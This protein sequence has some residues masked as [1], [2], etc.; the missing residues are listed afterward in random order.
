MNEIEMET[1]ERRGAPDWL[2]LSTGTG[3]GRESH[4]RNSKTRRALKPVMFIQ[5]VLELRRFD[6]RRTRT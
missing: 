3:T 1:S 5:A 6:L 4:T 2:G